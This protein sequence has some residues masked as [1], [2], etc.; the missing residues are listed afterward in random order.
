MMNNYTSLSII[1]TSQGIGNSE[2]YTQQRPKMSQ[3]LLSIQYK[4][5][6]FQQNHHINLSR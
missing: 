5:L 6:L 1:F 2:K 3:Y 4:S